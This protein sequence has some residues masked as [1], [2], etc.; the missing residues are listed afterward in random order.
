VRSIVR[1]A[2]LL[3]LVLLGAELG[4]RLAGR[5][6]YALGSDPGRASTVAPTILCIGES[7]T[8][9]LWMAP[10]DSYPEQLERLI[11]DRVGSGRVEVVRNQ[12][13]GVNTA[14]ILEQ[15][16]GMLRRYHPIAVIYMVGA[17]NSWSLEHTHIALRWDSD[18][19]GRLSIAA[20]S[21]LDRSRV[22]KLLRFV[23]QR[24]SPAKGDAWPPTTERMEFFR[25]HALLFHEI[26]L[27]DLRRMIDD[28]RAA[29]AVPF[30]MTYP[31]GPARAEQL[32]IARERNV[33]LIDLAPEFE[34]LRNQGVIESYL[35]TDHWH[36]NREGYAVIARRALDALVRNQVVPDHP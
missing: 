26:L 27:D 15:L 7:S 1:G 29:R 14:M 32:Q 2:A 12:G 9:G 20:L 24:L 8:Y 11:A 17:N 23:A 10:G 30:I 34:R 33:P 19:I 6:F 25:R 4:L 13:V 31:L 3:L 22:F 35:S 18:A 36:P 21:L 5:L 28:A 16:P